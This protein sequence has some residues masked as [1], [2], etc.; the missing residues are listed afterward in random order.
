MTDST[1]LNSNSTANTVSMHPLTLSMHRVRRMHFVGIG[2]AGMSG[3]AEVYLN[4]GF[5]VSG[6]DIKN[7]Q[8]TERLAGLG[9][10]IIFGHMSTNVDGADVVVVSTAI[11]ES[12][13]EIAAARANRIPIVPRAEMLAEL[14][15][16]HYGIAIAGTHGKTTTTSLTASLLAE[17]GM[18]PTFVIGGKLNSIG[19][20]AK[21][22][23]GRYLVA[24][25]D[26]SDASFLYLQPMM[27]VITNIDVDHMSTYDGDYSKLR[28]TFIDFLHHLPFYGLAIL[29]LDDDGV[30]DIIDDVTCPVLTYGFHEKADIRASNVMPCGD[31]A[32]FDL[33]LP[34][35]RMVSGVELALP[36]RHN[37]QN[38]L[39]AIA[40][41][42]NLDADIAPVLTA[43]KNFDGIGRRFQQYGQLDINGK[44]I[45]LVDDY[46]HHP[47]EL[48][49]TIKAAKE[50]WPKRRLVVAFQPH[51][52]SR[53]QD[54]FEDFTLELSEP[55][56]LLLCEVFAAGEEPIAGADGRALARAVRARGRAE[57]VF[58]DDANNLLRMLPN[59]MQDGDILL[60]MG[61]GNIGAVAAEVF[62]QFGVQA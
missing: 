16:F 18:D 28:Q 11:D 60:T 46:G 55:D 26:E 6:S 43:L 3:I 15:R 38:A 29:C 25:A 32:R 62:A 39:A 2:G 48:Q 51:R 21:L 54:L 10:M 49:A 8:V 44:N 23:T 37:I 30:L 41:A 52:Y 24:E 53:T 31:R 12:N 20:N 33:N 17:A 1:D 59:V 57:P 42:V 50:C 34:N 61:A 40:V 47:R 13:P 4:L 35:G 27:S 7:S 5:E 36:G 56:Q 14:M 19:A 58:V 22:G 9:A 45:H